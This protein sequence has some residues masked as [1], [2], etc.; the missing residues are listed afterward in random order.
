MGFFTPRE[1]A[2]LGKSAEIRGQGNARELVRHEFT[3]RARPQPPE[4]D[5]SGHV[6]TV[7]N[8]V[9]ASSVQEI[10]ELI[11]KLQQ[12]RQRLLDERA[13]VQRE[14]LEYTAL[15][16]S[17]MQSTKI[18]SESLAQ[19]NKVPDAPRVSDTQ[20]QDVPA[21]EQHSETAAEQSNS[22]GEPPAQHAANESAS[23]D[24]AEDAAE[25]GDRPSETGFAG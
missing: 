4:P 17:T 25:P 10:D 23:S 22:A 1:R 11:V 18:I 15:S 8:G 9:A 13:R 24:K 20:V 12:R 19:L 21:A 7:V 3:P 6:G 5:I 16:Q 2:E 14:I